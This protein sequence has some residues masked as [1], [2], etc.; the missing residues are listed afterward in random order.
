MN[1][2]ATDTSF[3]VAAGLSGTLGQLDSLAGSYNQNSIVKDVEAFTNNATVA[4]NGLSVS[5]LG[6]DSLFAVTAGGAVNTEPGTSLAGSVNNNS[7]SNTVTATLGNNTT[8]TNIGQGG[9]TVNAS[10][11][12]SGD[13]IASVAGG[14]SASDGGAGVGA[15]VDIGNYTNNVTAS[16]GNAQVSSAGNVQVTSSTNVTYIPIAASL[17]GVSDFG[18]AGSL[19]DESI[20]DNTTSAV[21]GNVTSAQNLLIGS[22]DSSSATVIAGGLGYGG[23]VGV[24]VSAIPAAVLTDNNFE[25]RRWRKRIRVWLKRERSLV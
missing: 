2:N 17:A 20:S 6:N 1:V 22:M 13:Q 8:A 12:N 19:A 23:N 9:I 24:G 16:I 10:E 3:A 15:A 4:A 7:V 25:H 21:A 5:A 11:G 14:I 18:V